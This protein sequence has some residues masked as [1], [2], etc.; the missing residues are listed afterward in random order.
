MNVINSKFALYFTPK[1]RWRYHCMG[2]RVV[3]IFAQIASNK[4]V[5]KPMKMVGEHTYLRYSRLNM[6]YVT[7]RVDNFV[8]T[9]S[10][11][12]LWT[13][14]LLLHFGTFFI[15]IIYISHSCMYEASIW[16]Y[17]CEYEQWQ[18]KWQMC[19]HVLIKF[20]FR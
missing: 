13:M 2:S 10:S 9:S 3:T 20:C 18:Y 7:K 11:L 8:L 17:K 19:M 6:T 12:Q 5:W 1:A 4:P 15:L 16:L 14:S